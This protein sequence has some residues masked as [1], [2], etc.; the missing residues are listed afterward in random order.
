MNLDSASSCPV[1]GDEQ[2]AAMIIMAICHE[3][4]A[5][6]CGE[7]TL[8]VSSHKRSTCSVIITDSWFSVNY[9]I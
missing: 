4:I 1:A 9:H 2:E 6:V 5:C 8:I 7:D 3:L